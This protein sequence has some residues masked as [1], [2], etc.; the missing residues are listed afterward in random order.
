[1]V[2]TKPLVSRAKSL[3]FRRDGL[4]FLIRLSEADPTVLASSDQPGDL[5]NLLYGLF[6]FHFL[7]P[8]SNPAEDANRL[9]GFVRSTPDAF[10]R[11]IAHLKELLA[12]AAD[13]TTLRRKLLQGTEAVFDG[14]ALKAGGVQ[15]SMYLFS[16]A[17]AQ[18]F[19]DGFEQAVAVSAMR[20]LAVDEG[21]MV[22]RCARESCKPSRRI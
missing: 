11:L 5:I 3:K 1:M 22:R 15:E 13:G 2:S 20:V 14:V 6:R 10:R 12:A 9:A 16:P 8:P 7:A 21:M 4:K 18:N 17:P 19:W